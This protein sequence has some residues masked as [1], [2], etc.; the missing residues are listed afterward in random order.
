MITRSFLVEVRRKALRR[1]AWFK[2]LDRVDRAFIDLTIMTVDRV[3]SGKL[4]VEIAKILK[5]LSDVLKSP[6]F[7]LMGFYGSE[8]SRKLSEQALFWGYEEAKNWAHDLAFT[9]FL[10]I[11][12]IKSPIGFGRR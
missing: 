9:Q 7:M 5:K 6:L 12:E 2:A 1:G 10:T 4:G 11:L 8:K 3:R